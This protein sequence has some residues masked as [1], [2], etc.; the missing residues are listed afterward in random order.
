MQSEA[1]DRANRV[2]DF[3]VVFTCNGR[4]KLTFLGHFASLF[5]DAY[6]STQ[7][8]S[9]YIYV[10]ICFLVCCLL[11]AFLVGSPLPSLPKTSQTHLTYNHLT[12]LR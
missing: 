5:T 2:G 11:F 9:L 6:S 1:P 10:H 8:V 4:A 12:V 7:P 3:W